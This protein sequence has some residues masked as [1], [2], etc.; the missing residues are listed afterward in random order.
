MEALKDCERVDIDHPLAGQH[1]NLATLEQVR[2]KLL[3]L[4]SEGFNFPDYV[5]EEVEEE[6]QDNTDLEQ[7]CSWM[8]AARAV[9]AS[10]TGQDVPSWKEM[11]ADQGNWSAEIAARRADASAAMEAMR[12]IRA[13]RAKASEQE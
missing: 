8:Q 3:Y 7:V 12:G 13:R 2:E 1:W 11:L 10:Q 9:A 6:M 4:R 5:L